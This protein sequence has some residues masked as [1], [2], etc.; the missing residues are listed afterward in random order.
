MMMRY[1][2]Q[3]SNG[4]YYIESVNGKLESDKYGHT[5]GESIDRFAELENANLNAIT[6]KMTLNED[7]IKKAME[8]CMKRIDY[9]INKIRSEAIKEFVERLKVYKIKPE[10]PWD[11]FV[12]CETTIDDLV[13]EMDG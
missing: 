9:N 3:D 12:I 6:Y 7:Q 4:R 13:K 11:D 1:T 8:D 10:F 5:Y 2:K